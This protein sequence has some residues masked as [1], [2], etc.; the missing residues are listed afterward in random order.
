MVYIGVDPGKNGGLAWIIDGEARAK[1]LTLTTLATDI[2]S[3][4][5]NAEMLWQEVTC[6]VE[7]VH[8]MPHQGSVSTF[9]FGENYGGILWTLVAVNSLVPAD[10]EINIV[11]P[12]KW[13]KAMGV[14]ADKRTSI[15]RCKEL[16]PDVDLRATA[17]CKK[18]HDGMA[19]ALL[20]AEYG[21]EQCG[22]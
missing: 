11:T 18:D 2:A 3:I 21:R 14:T 17:R 19:E 20:I 1:R 9:S 12:Q 10:M 4:C 16:F 7:Q 13:K 5:R 22:Y 6:Y 15:R 8:A